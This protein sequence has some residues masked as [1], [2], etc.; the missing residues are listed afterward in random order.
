MIVGVC[1]LMWSAAMAAEETGP[2]AAQP[3]AP[4]VPETLSL[5]QA[6]EIAL[7]YNPQVAIS[8]HGV[9]AARGEL[10]QARSAL[11]PRLDVTTQ[12][13]TPVDLPPFTF[14]SRDST[15]ETS[16]SVSQPL[17][18]GGGIRQGISA[19]D[20]YFQGSV[21]E[22]E[23][24]R[25]EVAFAA[26]QSY[27]EVIT[28]EEGV[29]VAQDVVGSAQEH[30]RLARLRY[31]AGV[32]PQFDALAAEARVARVEQVLFA[33]E[34]D[35]GIAWAAL[36]RVLG[37][38]I[39]EGT[40]L[41][42]PR[43]VE[44]PS[45]GVEDLVEEAVQKR[46]DLLAAGAES[47]AA[48]AQLLVAKAKRQPS[49]SLAGS[50]TLREATTIPGEELGAPGTD[51]VVS[52]SSG[53]VALVANWSLYNGGQVTGEIKTAEARLRQAE[54]MIESLKQAIELDVRSAYLLVGAA[55]SQVGAA[56][57]EVDQAQEAHRIAT[58]RYEEGVGTSVEILDAEANLEGAKTR[59]N[60]AVFG[61]NL[62]V[63]QLDLA[64][65]RGWP[66]PT[67]SEGTGE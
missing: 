49:V 29:K 10:T 51:I 47:A 23:R 63:A 2:A 39:P 66:A 9:R 24:R 21:G 26:R 43:P 22:F 44:M 52:Q 30:L 1:L 62:A 42:T 65:G 27:Y 4:V 50:Y 55:R 57:K 32:A 67:E 14:Q 46:P 7:Q 20:S 33:A 64:V 11:H 61:L 38:P 34:A 3:E 28:A 31:E 40:R 15:W 17:Y 59:L 5:E 37:V 6:I 36:S 8:E 35:R 13:V 41:T 53:I 58:L 12:R 48:R 19:A 56:Q 18:T 16:F 25:Q 60:E 54:N 45:V